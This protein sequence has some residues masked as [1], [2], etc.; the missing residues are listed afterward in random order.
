M[1]VAS[2]HASVIEGGRELSGYA[3]RCVLRYERRTIAGETD[4]SVES[5][6]Q[7]ILADPT[8]QVTG[9]EA[10]G[11]RTFS[12][13]ATPSTRHTRSRALGRGEGSLHQH[14]VLDRRVVL[15]AAGSSPVP[16]DQDAPASPRPIEEYVWIAGAWWRPRRAGGAR[17]SSHARAQR[18]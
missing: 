13:R 5:E 14:D 10:S 1:G 9:V 12:V 2:L 6:L 3:D 17:R 15:A 8:A 16:L 4:E 11:A 18:A 7:R